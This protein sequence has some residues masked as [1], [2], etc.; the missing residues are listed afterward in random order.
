MLEVASLLLHQSRPAE[1]ERQHRG[2]MPSSPAASAT[3]AA[4]A[5]LV[6]AEAAALATAVALAD[7]SAD[8]LA[9]A[10]AVAAAW[11]AC[12]KGVLCLGVMAAELQTHTLLRGHKPVHS[13]L[14]LSQ[15]SH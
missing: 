14:Q 3:D 7:A 1:E 6:A 2:L 9:D 11:A 5:P 15:R 10:S 4:D 12:S 13:P 8:E